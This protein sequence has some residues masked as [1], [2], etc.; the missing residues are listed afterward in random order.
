MWYEI[1]KFELKYRTKRPET[2]VFFLF[3]F[4]FSTV[5]V[6]F[7]FQ[8][9][10]LGLMK[11]NA[12][13]VVAK[14]MGAI[15]GIFMIM[16][17]M[18][19]GVPILRDFQYNMESLL[20]VN[21]IKKQDYLVGRFL[22]SFTVLL[23]IFSAVLLGMMV[24]EFMPWR[25]DLLPFKPITYLQSFLVIVVPILFFGACLFFIAGMLSRKLLVV[26]TQGIFLFV[27]FLLTKAI[28]NEHLQA[29]LDPFSLTT[30]TNIAKNWSIIERNS[31]GISFN[32]VMLHNK[33]FWI[34]I[35]IVTLIIG[36]RK[37]SF[38]LVSKISNSKKKKEVKLEEN[39]IITEHIIPKVNIHYTFRTY[40]IQLLE[41]SKFIQDPYSKRR[42]FGRLPFAE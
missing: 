38:S 7:I 36:Y 37:F 33:L 9:V 29:I 31:L 17:S 10:E 8:G 12:P 42:H 22:G 2:Y 1:F 13:L 6:D 20:F 34:A 32:G 30:L 4:L 19:M 24:G 15:T 39:S 14:T 16:A 3:L 40:C 11:K 26:Y 35:G 25:Q 5:G 18:I 41:L 27:V 23:F 28:E 21:P